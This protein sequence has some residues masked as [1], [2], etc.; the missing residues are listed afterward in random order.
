MLDMKSACERCGNALPAESAEA[1]MCS[2][3]CTF[4]R[5]CADA[6]QGHCPNCGG[7]LRDRPSRTHG[8]APDDVRTTR[9]ASPG[10]A[11]SPFPTAEAYSAERALFDALTVIDL[12]D[13]QS[14]ITDRYRN[15]VIANVDA[16]CLR[17]AVF[18]EQ[19][20]WHCHPDSDE[21]FLVVDGTLEIDFEDRTVQ[22][23]PWQL[24]VVPAGTVHRTRAVGRTV[25]AT[26]EQQGARTLFLDAPGGGH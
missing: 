3:E 5:S 17:L 23:R 15:E 9:D 24:I 4:C 11:H 10:P 6:M 26:F 8:Q 1:R 16:A 22:L 14:H 19:Y 13:R 25:N 2:Y 12:Q 21:L 7:V 18:Q 20:R